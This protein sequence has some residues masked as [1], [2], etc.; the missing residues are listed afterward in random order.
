MK[1]M[2]APEQQPLAGSRPTLARLVGL[3]FRKLT[4]VRSGQSV[5]WSMLGLGLLLSFGV[6]WVLIAQEEAELSFS[7]IMMAF[8]VCAA[9]G[10]PI[11]GIL[12]YTM[13][14][15]HRDILMILALEP[16]RHRVF[17]AKLVTSVLIGVALCAAF[18]ATGL[19]VSFGLASAFGMAWTAQGSL[20]VL[21]M[22]IVLSF[23]G[24]LSGAALGSALLS[25]PLSVVIVIIQVLLIDNLLLL[26]PGGIG[27]FLQT[28]SMS[29]SLI[30]DGSIGTAL[31]SF[32]LWVLLPFAVGFI[33]MRRAEPH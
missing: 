11:L 16:R 24:S 7:V 20:E 29:N 23:A 26:L 9:L 18:I 5:L 27:P 10:T 33:R 21:G 1:T 19:A 6:C 30:G 13:D 2:D 17:L 12:V 28:A 22:L 31:S 25:T 32:A 8:T 15:Q 3:E 4:T 14:W